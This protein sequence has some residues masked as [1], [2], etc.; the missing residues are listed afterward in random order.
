MSGY[1]LTELL[2]ENGFNVAGALAGSEG[3]CVLILEAVARLIPN[4]AARSLV[5]LGY[6]DV[7]TAAD[8]VVEVMRF[9]PVGLEGMDDRLVKDLEQIVSSKAAL[10]M[11]GHDVGGHRLP[12][13]EATDAEKTALRSALERAGILAGARA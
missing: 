8:A 12:L 7:F 10:N 3:T 1:N 4:P 5:V 11:L 6:P 2:P 13:V 9:R